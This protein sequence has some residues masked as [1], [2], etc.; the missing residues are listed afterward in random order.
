MTSPYEFKVVLLG[1]AAVGK[2]SLVERLQNNEFSEEKPSTIGAYFCIKKMTVAGK[3]V[4]LN[5]WDTAGQEKFKSLAPM[6]YR[7][8]AACLIL[9]DVTNR[10]SF[11]NAK[12]WVKEL[13]DKNKD[14]KVKILIGNKND[15]DGKEIN[16]EDVKE[17]VEETGCENT[18]EVSAKT[19]DRVE[20]VFEYLAKEVMK[21]VK[22]NEDK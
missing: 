15:L 16:E 20:E 7:G 22:E 13:N 8:A 17:F 21:N 3:E 6:Y 18:F 1:D 12:N 2:S 14:C 5:I 4:S 10:D 11:E 9:Y 19:G